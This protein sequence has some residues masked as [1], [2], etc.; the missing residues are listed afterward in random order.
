MAENRLRILVVGA[1]PDDPDITCGGVAILWAAQGHTVKFLSLTNGDTGHHA[2]GGIELARRRHA[3]TQASARTAGIAEYQVI[4]QHCGELEATLPNRKNL[5]RIIREFRPDLLIT[6]RPNDY[7]PDHRAAA[8]LV[9]DAS[10]IMTVPNMLALT[11]IVEKTPVIC[12][13]H[14]RFRK[15]NPFQ[16]D[17]AVDIDRVLE[18]KFDMLDCHVSQMYEWLPFNK[19]VLDQVPADSKARRSW[20]PGQYLARFQ[21]VADSC[22]GKLVE[23]YGDKRGTGVQCAEAFEVCEY[24]TQADAA[25]LK[26]LFPFF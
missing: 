9:Q 8:L 14:D 13:V 2:I 17:I 25:E 20:L 26:R 12:Y 6:N 5:I 21:D 16:A 4:D 10:Y 15:P 1:H 23:L 11:D 18:R 7:H 3:E 22:R 19:G 24:G